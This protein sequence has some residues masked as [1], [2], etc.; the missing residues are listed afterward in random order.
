M[1]NKTQAHKSKKNQ[2]RG[3][4]AILV[5]V[6]CLSGSLQ[7]RGDF[8]GHTRCPGTTRWVK[9]GV[10]ALTLHVVPSVVSSQTLSVSTTYFLWFNKSH[11]LAYVMTQSEWLYSLLAQRWCDHVPAL[12]SNGNQWLLLDSVQAG[13]GVWRWWGA[14]SNFESLLVPDGVVYK[15]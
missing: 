5:C 13:W 12:Q 10:P 14:G 8:T 7:S 1:L 3:S 15:K 11:T 2:H 6:C 4:N 9:E